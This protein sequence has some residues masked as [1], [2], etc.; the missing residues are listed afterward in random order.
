MLQNG[1]LPSPTLKRDLNPDVLT[2]AEQIAAPDCL[3]LR[4]FLTPL[5]AAGEL[6][7]SAVAR[8]VI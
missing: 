6:G 2:T 5:S 7:R 8:I 3:Q 1:S 4:S